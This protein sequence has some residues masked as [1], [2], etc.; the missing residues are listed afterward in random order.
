LFDGVKIH[1]N[2]HTIRAHVV[3]KDERTWVFEDEITDVVPLDDY[4]E[5]FVRSFL[6]TEI[7]NLG[8]L[9]ELSVHC[10]KIVSEH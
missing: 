1:S 8:I 4:S 2:I 6:S 9:F 5:F 7:P 10:K 3:G